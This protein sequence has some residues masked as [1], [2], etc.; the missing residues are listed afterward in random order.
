MKEYKPPPQ[1]KPKDDTD[2]HEILIKAVF[3]AVIFFSGV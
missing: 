2:Y 1:K 3:N